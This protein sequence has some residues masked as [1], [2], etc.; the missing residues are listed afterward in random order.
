LKKKLSFIVHP[1]E[2]IAKDEDINSDHF[3]CFIL[4][5]GML[6]NTFDQFKEGALA[7][8]VITL[9]N[10][11]NISENWKQS[12]CTCPYFLKKYIW[13]HLICLAIRLK[14][15]KPPTAAKDKPIS[16]RQDEKD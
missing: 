2:S 12:R 11:E 5:E 1:K 10:E 4:Y 6:W 9:P 7:I 3:N 13:K 8:W 15:F 16:Q 14:Y